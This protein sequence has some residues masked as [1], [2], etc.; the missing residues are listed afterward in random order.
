MHLELLA[1]PQVSPQDERLCHKD[2]LGHVFMKECP[3]GSFKV[4]MKEVK[5]FW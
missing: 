4:K 2:S 5:S 3:L 1:G